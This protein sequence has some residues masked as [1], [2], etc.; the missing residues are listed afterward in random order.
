MPS[1]CPL[2]GAT[3]NIE[4]SAPAGDAPC[5]NC[6]QLLWSSVQLIQSVTKRYEGVLGAVDA[7]TRFSDLGADS[8]DTVEMLIGLEEEYDINIPADVAE[9]IQTIGDVVRYIQEHRRLVLRL[10]TLYPLS[11]STAEAPCK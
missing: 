5:P 9:R 2:C 1:E 10:E 8:L 6:G 4:F 11:S 3:T 7:N